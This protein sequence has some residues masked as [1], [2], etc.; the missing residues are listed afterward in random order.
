[1]KNRVYLVV[2]VLFLVAFV[3]T[4]NHG[5]GGGGG[6][7]SGSSTPPPA[8]KL[9]F[10][11][12]PTAIAAGSTFSPSIVIAVQDANG[13]TVTTAT[14]DI[15]ITAGPG[16]TLTGITTR[17]AVNGIATFT[18][19]GAN[20]L[21]GSYTLTA[22]ATGLTSATSNAFN[23]TFGTA[24]K[25]DF[26]QHPTNNAPDAAFNP[27]VTVAVR[28]AYN[29]TVTTATNNIIIAGSG[30]LTLGGTTTRAAVSGVATFTGL[31][32]GGADGS[33]YT[34]NASASG[35]TGAT[36]NTF[37]IS[38]YGVPAKLAFTVQ[39]TTTSAGAAFNPV[40]RVVV[41]DTYGNL[42]TTATNT[43][44][45]SVSGGATLGGTTIVGASSGEAI[46]NGVTIGGSAA[47]NY[48]ITATSSGLTLATS[49]TFG[50]TPG[51]AVKL[52]FTSQPT[53]TAAGS[54]FSPVVSVAV[55]DVYDNTVTVATNSIT[56]TVTPPGNA[57]AELGDT[58][59]RN[60]V[61]GI[62]NFTA[63]TIGGWSDIS[64]TLTASAS[65]LTSAQSNEFGITFGPLYGYTI[66]TFITTPIVS[67]SNQMGYIEPVDAYGNWVET[68]TG[69]LQMGSQNLVGTT[70]VSCYTD[71]TY[72]AGTTSYT[73]TDGYVWI[74]FRATGV[75]GNEFKIAVN[76][77]GPWWLSDT[78]VIQ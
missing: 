51:T 78:I 2:A 62:A 56:I 58:V 55:K 57:D 9:A 14:N 63:V 17:A 39:P 67:G 32:A 22:T 74:W 36:S 48:V 61:N 28:D 77:G 15:T 59:T 11:Q 73:L 31:T 38:G 8:T 19:L 41:Q 64:Y 26:I 35:L 29:N 50:I 12:Q 20:C 27:V 40:V 13:N 60:A 76:D 72:S 49:N 53:T 42:V 68:A 34:L 1:M 75:S 23:V 24:T 18:V 21:A 47:S 45:L 37:S 66:D 10:T 71:S 4:A 65:T 69:V 52:A 70:T 6:G 30:G 54:A 44:S 46:F 25:L 43:V 5:C 3:A 7:D 16:L 33:G